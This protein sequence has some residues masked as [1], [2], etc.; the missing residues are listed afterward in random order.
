MPP[1]DSRSVSA[2]GGG[3]SPLSGGSAA[4]GEDGGG[5][6]DGYSLLPEVDE[7]EGELSGVAASV[8]MKLLYGARFARWDLLKAINLLS[9]RITMWNK[10]CD[11]SLYRLM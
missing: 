1:A 6:G 5:I 3:H 11:R 2:A 8:L 7:K 9:Q 4:T 10:A